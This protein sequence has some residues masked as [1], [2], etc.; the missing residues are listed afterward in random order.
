MAFTGDLEHL[1]IVDIIQLVH[2]TRKSGIFSVKGSTGESK[3]VFSNGSIVGANHINDS[4]RIGTVLVKM[5]AITIDDLKQALGATN[6]AGKDH[7][8]L[9]V[10]LMQMGKLKRE[11]ALKGLKK[12]VELT[13]VELMNWTKGTFTFDTDTVIFSSEG[14]AAFGDM[15][16]EVGLD[17]Q[18]ILMDALRIFDERERDRANGKEVPSF[19]AAYADVLPEINAGGAKGERPAITADDLGLA[20]IDLLEKKIPRPVSEMETFDPVAIHRQNIKEILADF[21]FEEQEVFVSFLKRSMD[22][23]AAPDA[24]AQQAGKAVVLFSNDRLIRH[25]VMTIGKEDGIPV[26]ATD[27]ETDLDRIVSQCLATMRMP[28]VVFDS[29]TGPEGVFSEEKIVALRNRLRE[30]YSTAP[31]L[32]LASLQESNFILQAYHEGVRAVLPKPLKEVRKETYI[33]DTIKFLGVFKSYIKGLQYRL[34]DTDTYVKKLKDDIKSLRELANPSDAP[35]V[36]LAAVAE[37]FERA[38]TFFVRASELTGERGIGV[39]SEKSMGPTQADRLKIP[40]SK[41]SIFRDVLE[42]GLAYYGESGDETLKGLFQEI[43][44]PLSP[45]V[46][47]LPVLCDRKVI[48]VVYGDFGKK[49]STPVRL[50]ILEILAQQVGMAL[51]YALFRRQV[52]KAAQKP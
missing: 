45:A 6:D 22:R 37:M 49:E 13:I 52:T 18:M 19:E 17:A 31:L 39:S 4:I 26:F 43:G 40:L 2:T 1:H 50:D 28:V 47:L 20:D 16:Q 34:D 38:V 5:G 44:K 8:P 10:T 35:L 48:A 14:G 33:P 29:P 12:L 36:I 46:V 24:A 32:Q 25:S 41:P 23:K 7:K 27:D 3:I 51:E 11:D 42:K 21:S 9:M 15:E 30:K